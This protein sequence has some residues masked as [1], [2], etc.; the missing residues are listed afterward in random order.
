MKFSAKFVHA[1]LLAVVAIAAATVGAFA[2]ANFR[3]A[4]GIMG[5]EAGSQAAML[6]LDHNK[7]IAHGVTPK[8]HVQPTG[9]G[10]KVGNAIVVTCP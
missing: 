3:I 5:V 8:T 1:A 2:N 4:S 9:F 7:D 6:C 10:G